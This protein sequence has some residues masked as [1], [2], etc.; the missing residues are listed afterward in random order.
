MTIDTKNTPGNQ[1]PKMIVMPFQPAVGQSFDGIG[2]GIHFFLGNLLGVHGGLTECWFGWRV[3]KIF[4]EP[5]L[6]K[7][8][9]RNH[10]PFP[11][12]Q[13]LG[14][15]QKVRYWLE[16]TY[17][18]TGETLLLSLV[19]HDTQER[20]GTS[21][22]DLQ[23]TLNDGLLGARTGFFQWLETCGLAFIGIENA[24]W[25]EQIS[26]QGLDCLGR[27]LE[28]LYLTYIQ[29]SESNLIDLT[30]FDRAVDVS[31]ESYLV[32]DL[33]GWALY[34]N[35]EYLLAKKAFAAALDLNPYG[36]GALSGMMFCALWAK[37]R[38]R[39]FHYSLAK[40]DCRGGDQEKA[41]VFV[42]KKLGEL[43]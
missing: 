2:L 15:Q 11:D 18:Q 42:D 39:A 21:K 36:L 40:A 29:V 16:G 20:R 12:I 17:R 7:D 41:R 4:P 9:C 34:K 26:C 5:G 6:F 3:K 23:V 19:L 14:E 43:P 31:K 25:P 1:R 28:A 35:G 22:I 27:G 33:K 32:Q 10:K 13:E 24:M 38:E 37:D 8:Y 30:W